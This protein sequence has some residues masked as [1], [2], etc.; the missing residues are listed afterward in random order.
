MDVESNEQSGIIGKPLTRSAFTK[1]LRE[2]ELGMA[3]GNTS[4]HDPSLVQSGLRPV[5]QRVSVFDVRGLGRLR[6]TFLALDNSVNDIHA[7]RNITPGKHD[8]RINIL[9][10][11]DVSRYSLLA[12]VSRFHASFN[13]MLVHF[14][15]TRTQHGVACEA[16]LK[17]AGAEIN[18]K[19]VPGRAD[20]GTLL[21]HAPEAFSDPENIRAPLTKEQRTELR[22]N[23][24]QF[25]AGEDNL[26]L[27]GVVS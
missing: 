26:I 15:M 16:L 6:E 5:R 12:D 18:F 23:R 24:N 11:E 25:T 1:T 17:H 7:T 8:D 2:R 3:H 4:S 21:T 14:E 10:P 27:R 13:L 22:K 9:H 19:Y 20:L